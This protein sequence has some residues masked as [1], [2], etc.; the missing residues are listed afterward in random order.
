MLRRRRFP[1][2]VKMRKGP[3]PFKYVLLYTVIFFVL[4]SLISLWVI[5][6]S[7]EPVLMEVATS[8]IKR[9]SAQVINES[10]DENISEQIDMDEFIIIHGK[11]ENGTPIISFNPKLYNSIRAETI[12]DIEKKL[13]I[14]QGNHIYE[15]KGTNDQDHLNTEVYY[16]PL[17]VVTGNSLLSN[18]GPRIP[19][20]MSLIGNV[21]SEFKT[22]YTDA[23]INNGF[24]ELFVN[25]KVN[26]QI[27]IP[28]YSEEAPVE[29]T[30]KIG[31]IFIP[32]SV[33]DYYGGDKSMPAPAIPVPG[34][35]KKE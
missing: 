7:I 23:G 35:D 21:E 29:H 6:E 33:P 1:K 9:V 34:K 32:G 3:L 30:V 31:D 4:S 13:G 5:D 16:I 10:I 12:K 18:F 14:D 24:L 2:K 20:E 26:L 25:F 22:K 11:N 27:V 8:E 15:S 19:I 17:G 28:T